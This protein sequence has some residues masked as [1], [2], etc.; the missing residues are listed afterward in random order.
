[1]NSTEL[2][3]I[4]CCIL[5]CALQ[6][7]LTALCCHTSPQP[8]SEASVTTTSLREGIKPSVTPLA[9]CALRLQ[10]CNA[11]RHSLDTL[12]FLDPCNLGSKWRPLVQTWNGRK[13]R[14]P[15]GTI[16]VTDINIPNSLRKRLYLTILSS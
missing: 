15:S 16:D 4:K 7:P 9:R 2:E 13:W 11:R 5:C 8:E 14:R 1:M 6:S 12:T 10:G 3:H